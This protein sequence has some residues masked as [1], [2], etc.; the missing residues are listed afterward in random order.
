[1]LASFHAQSKVL[2]LAYRRLSIHRIVLRIPFLRILSA[3]MVDKRLEDSQRQGDEQQRDPNQSGLRI[4]P[5]ES[6]SEAKALGNHQI[7]IV[8]IVVKEASNPVPRIIAEHWA[9]E[10]TINGWTHAT[11]GTPG[12]QEMSEQHDHQ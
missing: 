3:S 1:M 7:G 10:W 4:A 8:R 5:I 12:Q 2:I 6:Q 9:G 11:P